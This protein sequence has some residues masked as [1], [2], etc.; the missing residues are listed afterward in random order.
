MKSITQQLAEARIAIE[1]TLSNPEIEKHLLQV[2]YSRKK[3]LEGKTLYANALQLQEDFEDKY[4][5]Q[6]GATK[7]FKQDLEA[8]N[9]LYRRH[10]KLAKIAYENDR[11][12]IS[13]LK[14][15]LPVPKTIEK[16]LLQANSFYKVLGK[17]TRMVEQFGVFTEELAQAR[18][19]TEALLEARNWQVS[20]KG[21]AR[22]TTKQRNEALA[23]LNAWMKEFRLSARYA[24]RENKEMLKVLGMIAAPSST[25]ETSAEDAHKAPSAL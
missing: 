8:A 6:H 16:W 10:R 22:N 9:V 4:G 21:F 3:V 20:T 14:L 23:A 1:N 12:K 25:E 5:E 13:V 15:R 24:L 19:M 7:S 11:R 18:A 2:G 17:D